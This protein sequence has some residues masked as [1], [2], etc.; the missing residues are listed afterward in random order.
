MLAVGGPAG[1]GPNDSTLDVRS[2]ALPASANLVLGQLAVG[3]GT[4]ISGVLNLQE[5]ALAT[6]SAGVIVGGQ[7]GT[8]TLTLTGATRSPGSSALEVG[9]AQ[10]P[11]ELDIG[12][13]AGST[14]SVTVDLNSYLNVNGPLYVGAGGKGSFR[15][16]GAVTCTSAVVAQNGSASVEGAWTIVSGNGGPDPGS[17]S[18]VTAAGGATAAAM[19]A[20]LDATT[21]SIQSQSATIGAAAAANSLPCSA[22]LFGSVWSVGTA[23]AIPEGPGK[24]AALQVEDGSLKI[25]D[26]SAVDAVDALVAAAVDA[27]NPA[28]FGEATPGLISVTPGNSELT[29]IGNKVSTLTTRFGLTLGV[30]A[31]GA[32]KTPTQTGALVVGGA[33]AT[34]RTAT[35][36]TSANR[37]NGSYAPATI[38]GG[39][40]A[41]VQQ[42]GSWITNGALVVGDQYN[43]AFLAVNSTGTVLTRGDA[44]V[45][46]VNPARSQATPNVSITGTSAWNILGSLDVGANQDSNV[47]I[48]IDH[49]PLLANGPAEIGN[50]TRSKPA[51]TVGSGA[52]LT[53][54][55]TE[56]APT[57]LGYG[58]GSSASVVV[59]AG[60][61]WR[62]GI[63]PQ[64]DLMIGRSNDRSNSSYLGVYGTGTVEAAT[65]TL[66]SGAIK[67]TGTVTANVNDVGGAILP[68]GT[69]TG[70]GTGVLT[71]Q[72]DLT[73][74][75]SGTLGIDIGGT[76]QGAATGGYDVL[77]VTGTA[78]LDGTLKVN[79]LNGFAPKAGQTFTILTDDDPSGFFRG[80]FS[81]LIPSGQ[82]LPGGLKWNVDYF[83][84]D[85]VVLEVLQVKANAISTAEG[86][87]FIGAVS[88]LAGIDGSDESSLVATVSW[89][90]GTSSQYTQQNGG[91]A[92]TTANGVITATVDGQKAYAEFGNYAVRTTF[93]FSGEEIMVDAGATV[94]E[95]PLVVNVLPDL[96]FTQG[97]RDDQIVAI[98]TDTAGMQEW[99]DMSSYTATIDWGD[100]K[101]T[102]GLVQ[103]YS[104][105]QYNVYSHGM[106]AY[107]ATGNYDIT[108]TVTD[109][110]G[111]IASASGS[112]TGSGGGSGGGEVTV[113]PA[114]PPPTPVGENIYATEGQSTTVTLL[115]FTPD[116]TDPPDSYSALVD[117]PSDDAQT[118][119]DVIADPQGGGDY[120]VV[121]TH[122]FTETGPCYVGQY[123]IHVDVFDPQ[124]TLLCYAW[125]TATIAD[126]PLTGGGGSLQAVENR[127]VF[128][129][130]GHVPG[131]QPRR[132]VRRF[133][134]DHHLG[135]RT[136]DDG[137]RQ[138][139]R[140]PGAGDEPVQR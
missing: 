25:H 44:S 137:H 26:G 115:S 97:Q 57:W 45:N 101:T 80:F 30:A 12:K 123:S 19:A 65:V 15:D 41:T 125:S 60:G 84:P 64:E 1:T 48:M 111:A 129:R 34:G 107:A 135:E 53:T 114:P 39:S 36:L 24:D 50:G 108:V 73:D 140:Q 86:A 18:L 20:S 117:W 29:L 87:T 52:T 124:Q 139:G 76:A 4:G 5:N 10:K 23:G 85:A 31:T 63:T 62:V 68:G 51:I 69:A 130:R 14:G 105:T 82:Q 81:K 59:T 2:D 122:T 27:E 49:S 11:M 8:G 112:G 93:D 74:Q 67:G 54:S 96:H 109:V 120:E 100:G 78:A 55:A 22:D 3:V 32:G 83:D 133:P 118:P 46:G 40:H 99:G 103:D 35:V 91:I 132:R 6:A 37:T 56:N 47:S 89:G 110:D 116:S 113:D 75:A 88:T 71:I 21:A 79:L 90:D 134:G 94:V 131:R 38:N 66:N 126:A 16:N 136:Q 33:G 43:A 104:E 13:G 128:R 72:G 58:Q 61:D 138:R 7:G 95:A 9:T 17:G 119:V 92:F 121:G 106:H 98:F 70:P 77:K 42:N 127:P 28:P 102:A